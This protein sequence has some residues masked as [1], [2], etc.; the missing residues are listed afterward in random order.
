M[1]LEI[2]TGAK[3]NMI[4]IKILLAFS[5]IY[6]NLN[7]QNESF[8][9]IMEAAKLEY[10]Y[11]VRSGKA[12]YTKAIEMLNRAVRVNPDNAE[13]HYFLGCTIDKM[14]SDDGT[15]MIASNLALSIKAS[16]EFEK[17]NKL[18]EP[19]QGELLILDPYSKLSSVWGSMAMAYWYQNKPD[20]MLWAF[21]Q[22]KTRGGFLDAFLDY[23]KQI[24]NSCKPNSILVTYGDNVTFPCYYLQTV[25]KFR[26]DITIVDAGLINTTWYPKLLKNK[27]GLKMSLTDAE[28]DSIDYIDWTAKNITISNHAKPTK[29][30]TW[31][32]SPSFNDKYILKGDRILKNIFEENVFERDLCFTFGSDSTYNLSLTPFF[33]DE[34]LISRVKV[35]EDEKSNEKYSGYNNLKSYNIDNLKADEIKKSR[36]VIMG[37][38]IYRWVFYDKIVFTYQNGMTNEAKELLNDLNRKFPSEKLPFTSK[39]IESKFEQMKEIINKN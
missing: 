33:A 19:Y 16:L 23:N 30:F 7:A 21:K 9:E 1:V 18:E 20:S 37:L 10:K 27:S 5:F 34:G 31:T 2:R 4:L 28:I 6:L 13:A 22:G 24:M 8:S 35:Q 25:E 12:D 38:H 15:K 39:E 26:T 17:A 32:L 3:I 29:T 36:D 14:N 11:Q